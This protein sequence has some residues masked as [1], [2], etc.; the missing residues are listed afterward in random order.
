MN[1]LESLRIAMRGLSSNKMRTALTMLGI[2]IGVAVVILVVAIGQ[3][4][5]KQVTDAVNSL[6]TNMLMVFPGT[7]RIRVNAATLASATGSGQVNRLK[8]SDAK[9]IAQ[10]FPESVAAVA[11]YVR[12]N[13]PIKFMGKDSTTTVNGTS[14]DYPFVNNADVDRGRFFTQ[15]D[16]DA[17]LKV[18]CVG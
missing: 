6:G 15:Q 5:T 8:L 12:S 9:L 18:C 4:A 2:I 16:M 14:P 1:L 10:N 11:P 17:S 13:E 7:A 3:G